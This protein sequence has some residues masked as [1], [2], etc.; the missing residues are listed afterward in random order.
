MFVPGGFGQRVGPDV[1]VSHIFPQG[2]L[3]AFTSVGSG[4]EIEFE[5]RDELHPG[6]LQRSST[7]GVAEKPGWPRVGTGEEARE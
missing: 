1:S 3:A 4:A 2:V 7:T 6:S 5:K